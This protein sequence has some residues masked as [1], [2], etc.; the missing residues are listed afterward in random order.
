MKGTTR[1]DCF[2]IRIKSLVIKQPLFSW[3]D[4]NL[5]LRVKTRL[6]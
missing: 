3:F 1:F 2:T 6:L 4:Y 5:G